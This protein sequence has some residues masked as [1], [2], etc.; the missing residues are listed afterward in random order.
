MN[1][2]R[3]EKESHNGLFIA[4]EGID[5]SGKTT[6]AKRV[7][8]FLYDLNK[9]ND[10][11]LTREPTRKCKIIREVLQ[12]ESANL[13][14]RAQWLSQLFVKDRKEHLAE[15]IEPALQRGIYVVCDRYKL[16]TMAYQGAQGVPLVDLFELQ[17][18]FLAPHIT[19][20][21]RCDVRVAQARKRQ[22]GQEDVFERD[23]EF[24][25]QVQAIYDKVCTISQ[26]RCEFIYVVD[27]N[28]SL[29]DVG[30]EVEQVLLRFICK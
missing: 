8:S 22:R 3:L 26:E 21:L 18:D 11:L 19:F 12:D 6:L 7:T 4:I 30:K 28:L 23:L 13:H 17:E 20:Y 14:A 9:E 27:A 25:E 29:E 24:Q 15:I 2:V 5:G 10:V 16:S 1:V